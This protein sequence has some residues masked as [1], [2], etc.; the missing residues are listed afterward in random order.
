MTKGLSTRL[1]S[2]AQ[3]QPNVDPL[4]EYARSGRLKGRRALVAGGFTGGSQIGRVVA[5]ALGKEGAAVA[6]ADA[7]VSDPG[8]PGAWPLP[9][10]RRGDGQAA[11]KTRPDSMVVETA[12][13][14]SD[15]GSYA[16][17]LHCD[18]ADEKACQGAVAHTALEFGGIDLLVVCG[19]AP[20]EP[21]RLLEVDADGL[22]R[23]LRATLYSAFWLVQSVSMHMEEGARVVLAGPQASGARGTNRIGHTAGVAGALSLA[24]SLGPALAERGI[25]ING[26]LA[27]DRADPYRL[28]EAYVGLFT[29]TADHPTGTVLPLMGAGRSHEAT[30]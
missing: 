28:A 13:L 10:P 14:V 12:G 1:W 27:D 17:P 25:A 30:G 23:D 5:T 3:R 29:G 11:T 21:R 7:V 9:A 4:P 22:E 20:P 2:V 24:V 19:T 18:L 26:L 15:F 6:L 16:L 8:A